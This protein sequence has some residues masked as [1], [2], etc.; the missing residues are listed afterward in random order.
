MSETAASQYGDWMVVQRRRRRGP[1]KPHSSANLQGR[2]SGPRNSRPP[3]ASGSNLR[4]AS[5][6][7]AKNLVNG[8]KKSTAM[9][10][11]QGGPQL[12]KNVRD[13][14]DQSRNSNPENSSSPNASSDGDND[15]A[16]INSD[17]IPRTTEPNKMAIIAVG[18]VMQAGE[19]ATVDRALVLTEPMHA[20][21]PMQPKPFSF[22]PAPTT[23]TSTPC[24]PNGIVRPVSQ[25]E[26]STSVSH[27]GPRTPHAEGNSNT[28]KVPNGGFDSD[29][30]K[31]NLAVPASRNTNF[32]SVSQ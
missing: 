10:S 18:H 1:Q 27:R 30:Q 8:G 13:L 17:E 4:P 15:S 5:D 7:G 21:L 26:A 16:A 23:T 6:S 19:A 29:G 25:P 24:R 3:K 2:D 32:S 20:G 28:N 31:G 12:A 22:G 14:Q 9:N 11:R